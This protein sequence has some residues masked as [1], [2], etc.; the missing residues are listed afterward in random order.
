[1]ENA[2]VAF[3]SVNLAKYQLDSK[4]VSKVSVSLTA[5]WL[6]FGHLVCFQ[7][8]CASSGLPLVSKFISSGKLTGRASS[9]TGTSPHFLQYII[10]IG[11][12]Q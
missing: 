1:M 12:P 7:V 10:G 4:K 6:Q 5:G 2:F 11:H 3:K 8:G 9:E